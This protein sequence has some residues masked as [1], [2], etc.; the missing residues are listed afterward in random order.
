MPAKEFFEELR[1]TAQTIGNRKD[2][3]C[4]WILDVII[5]AEPAFRDHTIP[6]KLPGADL[7]EVLCPEALHEAR[8][9]DP[10]PGAMFIAL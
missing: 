3:S 4:M 1:V 8:P 7:A 9:F 6:R 2:K 10:L 5:R